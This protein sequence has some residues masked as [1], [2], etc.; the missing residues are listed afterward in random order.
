MRSLLRRLCTGKFF[1]AAL[2]Y[3]E[4]RRPWKTCPYPLPTSPLSIRF[5]ASVSIRQ[6]KTASERSAPAHAPGGP[7]PPFRDSTHFT[8]YPKS[9]RKTYTA[10]HPAGLFHPPHGTEFIQRLYHGTDD[11]PCGAHRDLADYS[12]P[13][14]PLWALSSFSCSRRSRTSSRPTP[15]RSFTAEARGASRME[16]A[17]ST[18]ARFMP[19]MISAFS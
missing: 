12:S 15:S 2:P 13:S 4:S 18:I 1:S 5:P 16:T 9:R 19:E 10:A 11:A 7:D 8:C 6:A 17:S 14:A 3:G